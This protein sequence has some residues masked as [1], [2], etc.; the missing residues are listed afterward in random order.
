MLQ[1]KGTETVWAIATQ[2][3]FKP[4]ENWHIYAIGN[5]GMEQRCVIAFHPPVS[6]T[7]R[8]LPVPVQKF[9]ALLDGTLGS[10]QDEGTLQE[11]ALI[12]DKVEETWANVALRPWAIANGEKADKP[13][14]NQPYND[15]IQVDAELKNWSLQADSFY[16][17]YQKIIS[18]YPKAERSLADYYQNQFGYNK[19][20]AQMIAKQ[21]TDFSFRNYFVF[22][23]AVV[24]SEPE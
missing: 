13:L 17:H 10:G 18:Q 1:T 15:R 3:V 23:K 4:L 20:E 12:R 22:S 9:A 6:D 21:V 16:R 7:L 5:A 11:T 14:S 19:N 2:R 24:R 8:L